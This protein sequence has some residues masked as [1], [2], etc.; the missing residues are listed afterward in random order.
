[1]TAASGVTYDVEIKNIPNCS[2][3]YCNDRDVCSHIVWLLLN[4]FRVPVEGFL[5]QQRG[6]TSHEIEQT[7]AKQSLATGIS[8]NVKETNVT[9]TWWISKHTLKTQPKCP[10]CHA[11][12]K[13]GDLN[14]TCNARWTPPHK[15]KEGKSFT[16]PRTFHFCLKWECVGSSPSKDSSITKPPVMFKVDPSVKYSPDEWEVISFLD[17]PLLYD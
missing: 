7:F 13:Q 2:C 3:R 14:T 15:T 12:I 11:E 6:Y 17:F 5:L 16:V 8:Q 1:L 4:R 10:T 9:C